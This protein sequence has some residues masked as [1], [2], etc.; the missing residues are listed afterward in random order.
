M[1]PNLRTISMCASANTRAKNGN[2]KGQG[3]MGESPLVCIPEQNPHVKWGFLCSLKVI[4][5]QSASVIV[6]RE[7]I[8]WI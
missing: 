6:V 8:I 3:R 1:S 4:S 7:M 5:K 2:K